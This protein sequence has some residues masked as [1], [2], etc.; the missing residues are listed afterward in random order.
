MAW[1]ARV[2]QDYR[3]DLCHAGVIIGQRGSEI[4]ALKE[5]PGVVNVFLDTRSSPNTCV[6]SVTAHSREACE[7]VYAEVQKRITRKSKADKEAR[8]SKFQRT[9]IEA[10]EDENAIVLEISDGNRGCPVIAKSRHVVYS[11]VSF[12]RASLEEN[13][14]RITFENSKP[15]NDDFQSFSFNN[16]KDTFQNALDHLESTKVQTLDFNVSPGKIIFLGSEYS[17]STIY[18][19]QNGNV[20]LKDYHF[21]PVYITFL[22]PAYLD[23]ILAKLKEKGFSCLNEGIPEA[24]TTV[25][26]YVGAEKAQF[27]VNLALDENLEEF[28][29]NSTD[30]R[31]SIDKKKAIERV[32][33]AKTVGEVL[34]GTG[35]AKL[36]YRKLT[37]L[38]HPDKNSH[39]GATEAFKKL[40]DAY[41]AVK[42]GKSRSTPALAIDAPENG[43]ES[44]PPKVISVKTAKTKIC[45]VTTFSAALLDVR[46]SLVTYASDPNG[47]SRHVRTVLNSCWDKRDS[48]G[49]IP[50]PDGKTGVYISCVKQVTASHIWAKEVETHLGTA[51]CEV[52][53]KEIREK[54]DNQA[55]WQECVEVDMKL[56]VEG[57]KVESLS[58]KD[59]AHQFVKIKELWANICPTL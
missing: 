3:F 37:L 45:T 2:S 9:Y 8:F 32:F 16:M 53:V 28:K 14:R 19:T 12:K 5:I 20:N 39:P 48:R 58:A 44:K 7:D 11:F 41:E 25:H 15:S 1:A 10:D 23:Q 40:S 22:N 13:F 18:R 47:L 6:L 43:P 31:L 26:L 49:G 52:T 27:S 50:S 33:K 36:V 51:L 54:I 35:S 34:E 4:K 24:Y 59:F 29:D 57:R 55:E 38:L 42:S 46:A 56:T 30:S 17:Q 21:R